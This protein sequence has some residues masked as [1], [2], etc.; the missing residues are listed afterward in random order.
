MDKHTKPVEK[1]G[2]HPKNP[3]RFPY[4]FKAL[5][6]T[7]PALANF[8]HVNKHDKETIDFTNPDAVLALNQA[9]LKHQY[10]I[11]YWNIPKGYLCP[12][13]PG[14]ADYL[15][16]IADLLKLANNGKFPNGK[17]VNV[18]DVGTGANCIYPII[19]NRTFRWQFVGSEVD[20]KAIKCANQIVESNKNLNDQIEIRT[21]KDLNNIFHGII[22]EDDFFDLTVCNPPFFG[23][24]EEAAKKNE[25]KVKNLGIKSAHNALNFGGQNTE[26]WTKGGEKA[27][28]D[29]MIRQSQA[30][31]GQCLWFTTLVSN[32]RNLPYLES[33][34]KKVKAL[35]VKTIEMIQGQ[36][37]SRILCWTF[38][39]K[40]EHEQWAE[41]RWKT[42]SETVKK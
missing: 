33:R 1:K 23:S 6:E 7:L 10:S 42:N 25:R 36:K 26:F 4:D 19:G 18:L 20:P 3:F 39:S 38:L 22:Q 8:V 17:L 37:K 2:L 16:H 41:E 12:P 31:E 21:Q 28:I 34:L 40:K 5:T 15:H 27:F 35:R 29:K 32:A 24:V 11:E 9:I 30:F 14:R 13:V